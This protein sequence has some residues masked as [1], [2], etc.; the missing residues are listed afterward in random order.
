MHAG[1]QH[2]VYT[3]VNFLQDWLCLRLRAVLGRGGPLEV[4]TAV[5][6]TLCAAKRPNP[7]LAAPRSTEVSL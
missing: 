4:P 6:M 1:Y 2:Q 3:N 7:C 5:A